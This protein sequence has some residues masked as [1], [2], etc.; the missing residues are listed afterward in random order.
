MC[1]PVRR[2]TACTCPAHRDWANDARVFF[3]RL[4]GIVFYVRCQQMHEEEASRGFEL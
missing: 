1:N 4:M 2:A 3:F